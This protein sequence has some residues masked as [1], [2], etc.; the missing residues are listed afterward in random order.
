MMIVGCTCGRFTPKTIDG[1]LHTF[2]GI[3][4]GTDTE[5]A[6]HVAMMLALES[7]GYLTDPNV[8]YPIFRTANHDLVTI[9]GELDT[10][11]PQNVHMNGWRL[12]C[13]T[14]GLKGERLY[15]DI[16]QARGIAKALRSVTE[17]RCIRPR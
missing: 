4:A 5:H 12:W 17:P 14:C 16:D 6:E 11:D 1:A 10:S 9:F 7:P 15:Q 3:V 2:G 8:D 13:M